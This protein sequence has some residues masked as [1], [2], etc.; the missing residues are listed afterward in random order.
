MEN[1]DSDSSYGKLFIPFRR[2]IFHYGNLCRFEKICE[3]LSAK[4]NGNQL[5]LKK[6]QHCCWGFKAVVRAGVEPATHGFSVHCSTNWAITP[7]LPFRGSK[8]KGI[9]LK[10]QGFLKIVVKKVRSLWRVVYR[11]VK[12]IKHISIF[13]MMKDPKIKGSST[14]TGLLNEWR[15]F[16][17]Q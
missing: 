1:P 7:S 5:S 2:G 11:P 6:P 4:I 15:P 17:F 8:N 9:H 12:P 16:I 13:Q 3:L 14:S 10:E